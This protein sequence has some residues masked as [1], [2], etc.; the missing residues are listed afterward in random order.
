MIKNPS[1]KKAVVDKQQLLEE[2]SVEE[3]DL[4]M[5][6]GVVHSRDPDTGK[7]PM[8]YVNVAFEED[9]EDEESG[10]GSDA[11]LCGKERQGGFT[12][13]KVSPQR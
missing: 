7:S 6:D 3:G 1:R 5:T 4:E 13:Q 9:E 2:Q 12:G 11:S 8:S 10:S